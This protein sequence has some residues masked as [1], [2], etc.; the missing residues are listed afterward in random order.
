VSLYPNEADWKTLLVVQRQSYQ[1]SRLVGLTRVSSYWYAPHLEGPQ[2]SDLVAK[3]KEI[4]AGMMKML[5]HKAVEVV[6]DLEPE[7]TV[8]D[9]SGPEVV[10]E[11]VSQQ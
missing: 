8:D 9:K 5:E 10:A 7:P 2:F 1:L 4:L 6:E 11:L 3:C